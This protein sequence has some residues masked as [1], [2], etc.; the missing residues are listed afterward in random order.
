MQKTLQEQAQIKRHQGRYERKLYIH[1]E[2]LI[3]MKKILSMLLAM[4]MM[5]MVLI[6]P[7]YAAENVVMHG[8]IATEDDPYAN[9]TVE[10]VE[11]DG[12]SYTFTMYYE[13][14]NQTIAISNDQN[15]SIDIVQHDRKSSCVTINGQQ[16]VSEIATT[17]NPGIM[18][19]ADPGWEVLSSGSKRISWAEGTT[20]AIVAAVIAAA[21][22]KTTTALVIAAIGLDALAV[23][24]AASSGGTVYFE[25]QRLQ[26]FAVDQQR[27][28]WE[29]TASTGDHYGP[30]YDY[31]KI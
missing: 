29:F 25:F 14:G 4:T 30:F 27:W 13:D 19:L 10:C 18:P 1:E 9:G 26:M 24:A 28:M 23:L 5:V 11:M 22:P 31:V 16:F 20:A 15:N 8:Q 12:I 17:Y 6:Q 7:A 2:E 21:L 3:V